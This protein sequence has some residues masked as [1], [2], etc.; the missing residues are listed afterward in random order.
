MECDSR[1][2][3][4]LKEWS[5]SVSDQKRRPE[6]L[7]FHPGPVRKLSTDL[8][9]I[10]HCWVYSEYTPGDGQTNCPK[11]VEF[12]DKII[13]KKSIEPSLGLH[14]HFVRCTTNSKTQIAKAEFL[15]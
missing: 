4:T 15:W 6:N 11:H 13:T 9:D 3:L 12:H 5:A 8:Y 2:S 1:Q 14:A 10:Y 7:Q